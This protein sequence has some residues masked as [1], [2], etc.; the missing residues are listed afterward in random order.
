[1]KRNRLVLHIGD[2]QMKVLEHRAK[3][4]DCPAPTYAK[5]LVAKAVL[6]EVKAMESGL[7]L[8]EYD[9]LKEAEKE[10]SF[11]DEV[12]DNNEKLRD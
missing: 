5:F 10:F 11:D 12:L 1:M 9:K 2:A 8:D 6:E 4:L 3:Q 7:T